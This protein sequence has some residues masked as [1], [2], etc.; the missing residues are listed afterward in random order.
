MKKK[1]KTTLI[2]MGFTSI[3]N[4]NIVENKKLGNYDLLASEPSLIYKYKTKTIPY[5]KNWDGMV[6]QYHKKYLKELE[7]AN[8]IEAYLQTLG[9]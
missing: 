4:I 5:V 6:T 7:I 3:E 8:Q 1:Y 9:L 2:E